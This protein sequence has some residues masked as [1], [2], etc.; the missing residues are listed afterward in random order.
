MNNETN[1]KKS[2][3]GIIA[4]ILIAVII[5]IILLLFNSC[6]KNTNTVPTSSLQTTSTHTQTVTTAGNSGSGSEVQNFYDKKIKH[7]T[8]TFKSGTSK[9]QKLEYWFDGNRYRLTW[10]NEDGSERLHMIC[11]DGKNLYHSYVADKI[12][13]ISY[14]RPEMHQWIFNGPTG[15]TPGMGVKEGN[16][17]VYTFTAKKLWDVEGASQKFYLEDLKIYSDGE[18]IVKVVT[19]TNSKQPQTEADLVTSVYQI[20]TCEYLEKISDDVFNIPYPMETK[21]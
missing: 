1:N 8:V 14:V 4:I 6:G 7:G 19:R 13:K 12:T 10:Y 20:D 15:W 2:K 18:K 9:D 11:Q 3:K 16:L 17:T 21:K 5:I